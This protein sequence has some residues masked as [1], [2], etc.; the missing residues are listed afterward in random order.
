MNQYPSEAGGQ[1]PAPPLTPEQM[2]ALAALSGNIT[3]KIELDDGNK[4]DLAV[5]VPTSSSEPYSFT[6][7]EEPKGSTT[8]VTLANFQF[9]SSN[10]Y[11]VEVNMPPMKVGEKGRVTAGFK[12]VDKP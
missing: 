6:L 9:T 1:P 8:P 11:S 7:K 4:Y 10:D 3:V 2:A 5:Q 12:L